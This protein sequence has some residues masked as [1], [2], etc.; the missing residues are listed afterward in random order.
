MS[1]QEPHGWIYDE[2]LKNKAAQPSDDVEVF[3]WRPDDMG[4]EPADWITAN[5]TLGSPDQVLKFIDDHTD[6]TL[7][8]WQ[9]DIFE[10]MYRD[11]EDFSRRLN[12]VLSGQIYRAPVGTPPPITPRRPRAPKQRRT[13]WVYVDEILL[14]LD[15]PSE[16][17]EARQRLIDEISE[18][19]EAKIARMQCP[20]FPRT[21]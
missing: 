4:A 21:D 2:V 10:Q 14:V 12:A 1:G 13:D 7:T 20:R 6:F 5:P 16:I 11:P 3:E 8:G 17:D 15:R 9:R 18:D 19:V